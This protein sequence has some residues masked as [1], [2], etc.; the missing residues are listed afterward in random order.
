MCYYYYYYNQL[1]MQKSDLI[2]GWYYYLSNVQ[3]KKMAIMINLRALLA[4]FVTKTQEGRDSES[5]PREKLPFKFSL[6][7]R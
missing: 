3:E 1:V 6:K 5:T 7:T 2:N 4:L